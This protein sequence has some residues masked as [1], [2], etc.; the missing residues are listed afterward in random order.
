MDKKKIDV[1]KAMLKEGKTAREIMEATGAP[2][3]YIYDVKLRMKAEE[4][5][6][7]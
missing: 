6:K 5:V 2:R 1:I 3:S 7:E 4:E